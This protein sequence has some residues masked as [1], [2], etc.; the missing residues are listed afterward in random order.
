MLFMLQSVSTESG[1]SIAGRLPDRDVDIRSLFNLKRNWQCLVLRPAFHD[2][3]VDGVRA[4][5]VCWV[6]AWHLVY[7]H[8]GFFK[9]EVVRICANPWLTW[10]SRGDLGVD[11]FFVIS[12]FLIGSILFSELRRSGEILMYRFYVRRF[13]RLTPVYAIAML[14]GLF[15]LSEVPKNARNMWANLLY[16]NN[17]LSVEKQYMGWCWSLAIEEQFYVLVPGFILLFVRRGDGR[18][19]YLVSLLLLSGFIR[20]VV[21]RTHGMIPPF[22]DEPYS[23]PW[24]KYYNAEYQNLYTRFGGLLAGV[25]G[26]YLVLY[27][28][29][30]IDRFFARTKLINAI[31]ILSLL[32]IVPIA[33]VSLDSGFF[34]FMPP[35]ARQVWYSLHRDIFS[36]TVMFLVLAATNSNGKIAATIRWLLS[37]KSFYPIAQLYYSVYLLHPMVML[38]LFPKTSRLFRGNLGPYGAMAAGDVIALI[39]IFSGAAMLYLLVEKPSMLARSL[40]VVRKLT[41]Y[42]AKESPDRHIHE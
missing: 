8:R 1:I 21:M 9:I 4:L 28:P 11:L 30:L 3:V 41:D 31:C 34:E 15:F 25:I 35:L 13:L 5:A 39:M 18:M 36:V 12:G 19:W 23:K 26:A 42:P 20:L 7:F 22:R 17:F 27:R 38:W 33:Y 6:V 29:S 16:V 14:L 40:P 10:I 37:W 24:V 2:P 32:V